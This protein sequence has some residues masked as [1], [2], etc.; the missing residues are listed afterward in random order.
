VTVNHAPSP[1][2]V[3]GRDGSTPHEPKPA[4]QS[5]GELAAHLSEQVSRLVRDEFR[6]AQ[7]EV[8]QKGKAAGLGGGLFGVA[9]LF[10]LCGFGVLVATAVL[11][12]DLV[13]PAWAA[14]LIV[15]GALLATAGFAALLGRAAL[16]KAAPPVPTTAID[17]VKQ[18]LAALRGARP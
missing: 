5:V 10:A 2:A 17:S 8:K 3:S 1:I 12:L 14:A 9:G 7:A 13:L 15:A 18:D 6:L 16:S 11:A 4:E